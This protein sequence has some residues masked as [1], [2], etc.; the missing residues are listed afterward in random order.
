MDPVFYG[1]FLAWRQNPGLCRQSRFVG[2]LYDEDADRCLDFPNGE[3]SAGVRRA[4]E[5][6]SVSIEEV[7]DDQLRCVA[8]AVFSLT[9]S[10]RLC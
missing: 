8:V 4:V 1:E 6:N 9:P 7:H 10:T 2:R 3:L 5:N